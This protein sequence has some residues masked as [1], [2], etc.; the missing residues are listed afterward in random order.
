MRGIEPSDWEAFRRF[1]ENSADMRAADMM[2]PPR[3]A[4]GYRRWTE[5]QSTRDPEGEEF[6]LA[7]EAN[8]VL[9]GSLSTSGTDR[10]AGR[11]SYGVSVGDE[12]KRRG[13]ASEAVV[14][15]MA[16]MFA[17]RRYHKCEISIYSVNEPS[18][19]L[20]E[21]LGFVTEGRLRDHVF[22]AGTHQDLV[23]LGMTAQEF[24]ARHAER[25]S[26]VLR[27]SAGTTGC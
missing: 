26:T 11:F 13:Y 14:L 4:E 24:W 19:R 12:H 5:E 2:Y 18:I 6:M 9:V 15:L 25:T 21:E 10:L 23:V 1:D 7:I 8:G 27:P 20:H 22:F 17:E 3:S 16:Y